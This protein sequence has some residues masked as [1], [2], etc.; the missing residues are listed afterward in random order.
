[1]KP[2]RKVI[3]HED[4][5]ITSVE[6][7]AHTVLVLKSKSSGESLTADPT[8]AQYCF[9]SGIETLKDYCEHKVHMDR[10]FEDC[11]LGNATEVQAGFEKPCSCGQ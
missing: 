10:S 9:Q 7:A 1:M 2:V 6:T 4:G 3:L 8:F 11:Q 5:Q